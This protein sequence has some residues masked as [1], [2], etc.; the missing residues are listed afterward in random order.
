MA[1]QYSHLRDPA[2]TEMERMTGHLL[3]GP[4]ALSVSLKDPLRLDP[5]PYHL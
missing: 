5:L 3:R 4:R 1:T 2:A